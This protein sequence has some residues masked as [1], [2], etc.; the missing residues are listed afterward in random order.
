MLWRTRR[1]NASLKRFFKTKLQHFYECLKISWFSFLFIPWRKARRLEQFSNTFEVTHN[2]VIRKSDFFYLAKNEK[3][4]LMFFYGHYEN[5]WQWNDVP[6][7]LQWTTNLLI[8][9]H[10]RDQCRRLYVNRTVV[11]TFKNFVYKLQ[12]YSYSLISYRKFCKTSKNKVLKTRFPML[13]IELG[14][15]PWK[16]QILST[17]S[18]GNICIAGISIE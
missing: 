18:H 6:T 11:Q 1:C 10:M 2:F 12:R 17:T 15:W 3:N 4:V 8:W 5:K 7:E 16:R 14:P 9:S 13:R